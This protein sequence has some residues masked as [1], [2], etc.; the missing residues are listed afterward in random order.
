MILAGAVS[1]LLDRLTLGY[2]RDF[3]DLNLGFTFNVADIFIVLG[4][5][6]LF[7]INNQ[8]QAVE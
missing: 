5:L 7:L 2:V 6:A 8:E 1:N 3:I 4:L